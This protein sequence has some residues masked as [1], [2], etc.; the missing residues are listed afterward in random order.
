MI[1]ALAGHVDHGKTSLVRALTGVDTDR[2]AEEKRRG[3]TIDLGFAYTDWDGERVGFVDV[4]GHHR[5]VNNMVAGIAS[6]QC[7]LLVVAADDGVMP[8]T[9]EH[10][11]ILS[12]IGVTRGVVALNKADKVNAARIEEVR[13]QIR[14]LT[15]GS[16]LAGADIVPTSTA[17]AVPIGINELRAALLRCGAAEMAQDTTFARLPIDRVFNLRGAG[18]VVTGTLMNGALTVGD[19][20]ALFPSGRAVRVRQLRVQDQP[21]ERTAP[22][23]RV[24]VN[25]TGIDT[26]DA[27]RGAWLVDPRVQGMRRITCELTLLTDAPHGLRHNTLTHVYHATTHAVATAALLDGWRQNPGET[28]LVELETREPLAARHGDR[29][30]VRDYGLDTTIGGARVLC[31]RHDTV[32]RRANANLAR[33]DIHRATLE[34]SV[35]AQLETGVELADLQRTFHVDPTTALPQGDTTRAVAGHLVAKTTWQHWRDAVIQQIS[36]HHDAHADSAGLKQNQ[37]NL[38]P[39]PFAA[40]LVRELLADGSLNEQTGYLYR[41][42]HAAELPAGLAKLLERV[43]A[44]LDSDAPLS[45]GDLMKKHGMP[46]KQLSRDLAALA[47]HKAIVRV[48][49]KRYFLRER[50]ARLVALANELSSDDGFTVRQ[51]RDA[52]GIGRNLVIEVLEHFDARGYTRRTGDSRRVVGQY[53]L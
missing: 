20:L 51:F 16:F 53:P 41:A 17:D 23:D 11:H 33:A 48:S 25:L 42:G 38:P 8:Q 7:A 35:A 14:N 47:G 28:R 13:G 29:L 52:S 32:R 46:M 10:L 9:A 12:L 44:D 3:L 49:E 50:L 31:E 15:A 37:L 39:A 24:A 5:F 26:D 21:A 22:G 4:P 6:G 43:R 34:D 18:T 45:V 36:A 40:E 19:E 27:E 1:I 2:L 30:I